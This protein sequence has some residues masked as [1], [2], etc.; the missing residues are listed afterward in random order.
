MTE[1]NEDGISVG[2]VVSRLPAS[3]A[4]EAAAQGKYF[5]D[6]ATRKFE[7]DVNRYL[8]DLA[9]RAE[10]QR[11]YEQQEAVKF[12]QVVQ[13]E[14]DNSDA[15]ARFQVFRP[16]DIRNN[17]IMP[18]MIEGLLGYQG[19]LNEFTGYLGSMKSLVLLSVCGA[20]AGGHAELWGLQVNVHGPV[21][22]VYREGQQ[23]ITWRLNAWES[24][25]GLMADNVVVIHDPMDMRRA[26]D[27]RDLAARV[28]AE[29]AVA[30]A[31][32]PVARTGGGAEDAEDFGAYRQGIEALR[33][34][35]DA[36]VI[37]NHNSGVHERARGRGHTTLPDGMDSIIS[38]V[39]KRDDEGGGIALDNGKNRDQDALA[40][41]RLMFHPCGPPNQKT[42]K[43]WSG[44]PLVQPDGL[45]WGNTLAAL[46]QEAQPVLDA[47][48][49]AGGSG[50]TSAQ[51]AAVLGINP[52]NLSKHK[53]VRMLTESKMIE[54]NGQK[55]SAVRWLRGPHGWAD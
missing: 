46:A 29:E 6:P 32:D 9:I 45:T 20:I 39:K 53:T 44:V 16:S 4:E 55:G 27:V 17:P 47:L 21:V 11:R 37:V 54:H 33:D 30:V 13:G 35:T 41:I 36:S 31:L 22:L 19:S 12:E 10:A 50:I 28:K 49:A 40:G 3:V 23:G 18:D 8:G 48:D 42:G 14:V 25:Y 34:A 1:M 15:L 43:P 26:E 5:V 7:E 51:L 24:Y 2:H 38:F 52:S